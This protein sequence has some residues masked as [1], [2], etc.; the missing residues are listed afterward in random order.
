MDE[1]IVLSRGTTTV[2]KLDADEQALMDEIEISVPRPQPARRPAPQ[3]MR[4]PQPQQQQ[5]AMDAFV[6]PNKQTAPAQTAQMMR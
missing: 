5:E 6:N 4:R 3:P 1:E 2:M